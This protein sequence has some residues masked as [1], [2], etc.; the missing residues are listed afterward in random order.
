MLK[1]TEDVEKKIP[2]TSN[3]IE[4]EDFNSLTKINFDT[5]IA[6]ASKNLATTIQVKTLIEWGDKN[7]EK[8]KRLQEFDL[9]YFI[10]KNYLDDDG[11]QN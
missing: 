2:D 3:F 1:K 6:E 11:S 8:L 4:T 10:G 5:R 9:S 7:S